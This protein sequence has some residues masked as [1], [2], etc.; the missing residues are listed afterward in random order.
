MGRVRDVWFVAFAVVGLLVYL[1]AP[2]EGRFA[3]TP[4]L[5]LLGVLTLVAHRITSDG[6]RRRSGDDEVS[7]ELVS[8]PVEPAPVERIDVATPPGASFPSTP[9]HPSAPSQ[10][11]APGPVASVS[12][13]LS[14]LPD[15][16]A[17]WPPPGVEVP[18]VFRSPDVT[19][20]STSVELS[21]G[22]ESSEGPEGST[23]VLEDAE[24]L[25]LSSDGA[26]VALPVVERR[27]VDLDATR[28][29]PAGFF[30]LGALSDVDEPAADDTLTEGLLSEQPVAEQPV[31]EQPV[32]EQPVAE[33]PA[34]GP[35]SPAPA[36]EQAPDQ[37]AN[38]VIDLRV[39]TS[40]HPVDDP[41]MAF[42]A[43]LFDQDHGSDPPRR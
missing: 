17:D 13:D 31:A 37:P 6:P 30:D 43:R 36:P 24:L 35:I 39:T 7:A 8:A 4:T 23:E 15:P 20:P 10:A 11:P 22:P 25:V 19:A 41:W 33:Q 40:Q 3:Q 1:V 34:S 12:E 29:I 26:Q 42:A 9:P 27:M 16:P 5:A 2:T 28:R 21:E 14:R 18:L 38:Q 32:I